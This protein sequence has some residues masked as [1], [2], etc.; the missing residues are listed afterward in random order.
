ML[1]LNI[2]LM[3]MDE[4]KKIILFFILLYRPEFEHFLD[5]RKMFL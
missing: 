3:R 2:N 1:N 4:K 5:L